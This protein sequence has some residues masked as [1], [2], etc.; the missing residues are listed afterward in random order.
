MGNMRMEKF[1]FIRRK[2]SCVHKTRRIMDLTTTPCSLKMGKKPLAPSYKWHIYTTF[3]II[4]I[5]F[6]W[7]FQRPVKLLGTW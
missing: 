2:C 5:Y 6:L 3:D 4:R 7:L 1:Y